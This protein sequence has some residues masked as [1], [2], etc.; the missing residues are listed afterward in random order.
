MTKKGRVYTPRETRQYEQKI[1]LAYREKYED[2]PRLQGPLGVTIFAW[3]KKPRKNKYPFPP[4]PDL[5][6]IVKIVFDSLNGLAWE[7][8]RQV[9]GVVA[10]KKYFE[11]EKLV[12]M[13]RQLFF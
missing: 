11:S 13:I 10:G 3:F 1:R 4:R 6:N 12:I 2:A 5:D 8:D 9:I 7:D